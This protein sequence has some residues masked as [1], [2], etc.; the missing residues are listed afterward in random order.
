VNTSPQEGFTGEHPRASP[1]N[2]SP[3]IAL[4]GTGAPACG[5]DS[6]QFNSIQIQGIQEELIQEPSSLTLLPEE[7]GDFRLDNSRDK[8]KPEKTGKP[9]KKRKSKFD[10][11]PLSPSEPIAT[12]SDPETARLLATIHDDLLKASITP[13]RPN[14]NLAAV[15]VVEAKILEWRAANYPASTIELAILKALD[16]MDKFDAVHVWH[17]AAKVLQSKHAKSE[18]SVIPLKPKPKT[19]PVYYVP[20]PVHPNDPRTKL[21]ENR[22]ATTAVTGAKKCST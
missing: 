7:E 21:Y 22:F 15:A 9:H 4:I 17:Y 8:G 10:L 16:A 3:E 5:I 18:P 1:V 14:G 12:V 2:T 11:E 13:R 20:P 6:I 19:E